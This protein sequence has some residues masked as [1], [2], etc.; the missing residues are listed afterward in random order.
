MTKLKRILPWMAIVAALGLL[1]GCASVCGVEK[2]PPKAPP[3]PPAV[4]KWSVPAT[5]PKPVAT[6]PPAAPA[7]P[8]TYTVEKCDDLWTISAKPQIYNDP[9]QWPLLW[10]AN[11]AKIANPNKIKEGTVLTV[12]RGVSDSDKAAAR[13]QAQAFP[14]YMPPKGAKRYCPP[15]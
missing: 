8:K 9:W 13:K 3:P 1:G 15:K 4:K 10:N 11:K 7:L 6:K 5:T 14:K 2:A 12:P